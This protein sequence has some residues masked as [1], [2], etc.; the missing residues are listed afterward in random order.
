MPQ[1]N[2]FDPT[3]DWS[4]V[5]V[6]LADHTPLLSA[7]MT[8]TLQV[9]RMDGDWSTLHVVHWEGL[10]VD[11]IGTY[12]TEVT[13]AWLFGAP[14]DVIRVA[15]KVHRDAGHHATAHAYD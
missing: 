12:V 7:S 15:K 2:L 8:T 6:Q 11:F 4:G 1:Q 5:R 13:T 10:M 14:G 9:Q 3:L